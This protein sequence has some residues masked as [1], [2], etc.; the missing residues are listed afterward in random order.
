MFEKP[1]DLELH[2]LAQ[3]RR[4]VERLLRP[5]RKARG[6]FGKSALSLSRDWERRPAYATSPLA[7]VPGRSEP[8]ACL[9]T[10]LIFVPDIAHTHDPAA[11]K[12]GRSG[13]TQLAASNDK[14]QP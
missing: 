9:P 13:S 14:R 11:S 7:G 6:H 2:P 3:A 1:P 12:S 4:Q 5:L 10:Q 8:I